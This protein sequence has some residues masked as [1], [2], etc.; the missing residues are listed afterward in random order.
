M[1]VS[2]PGYS[3]VDTI[4][5][6]ANSVIYRAREHRTERVVAIKSVKRESS[7]DDKYIAQVRNEYKYASQ[8][9]HINIVKI[10]K[11]VEIRRFF[12]L[13]R[14]LLVMEYVDGRDLS[15]IDYLV[16]P[17][18]LHVFQQVCRALRYLHKMG[19][20]HADMKPN[21]IL[22]RKDGR[23]KVI[24]FGLVGPAGRRRE[25]VQGTMD[26]AAPE[27]LRN[28]MIDVRTDIFN[29][30]ATMYRTISGRNFPCAAFAQSEVDIRK[31]DVMPPGHYVRGVPKRLDEL[32]MHCCALDPEGRPK[33]INRV[34]Q[35]LKK[36]EKSMRE[37][38]NPF[39]DD[40]D[41]KL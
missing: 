14:Y 3:I 23:V 30:G 29:F 39:G 35:T 41:S 36:I 2:V 22:V 7:A 26:Y 10:F 1:G 11:R 12:R 27:Q 24:D 40:S 15:K 38:E 8:F 28:K 19:L 9:D 20:V 21:N 17:A 5:F 25:R 31:F 32:V 13:S 4:G 16:I 34:L 6:G 18:L 33:S 37:K